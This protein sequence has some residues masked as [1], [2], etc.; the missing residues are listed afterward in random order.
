MV[1]GHVKGRAFATFDHRLWA[2]SFQ[3]ILSTDTTE[4]FGFRSQSNDNTKLLEHH[5]STVCRA[6]QG[7]AEVG[8][9]LSAFNDRAPLG[10]TLSS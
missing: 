6:N 10:L 2:L 3:R 7:D 1:L 4:L 9:E 8:E 5:L